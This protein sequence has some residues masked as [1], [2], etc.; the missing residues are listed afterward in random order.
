M[1]PSSEILQLLRKRF[2]LSQEKFG[3]FIGL[4]RSHVC[5]IETGKRYAPSLT[6]LEP[7]KLM[8]KLSEHDYEQLIVATSLSPKRIRIPPDSPEIAFKFATALSARWGSMSAEAFEQLY[9]LVSTS[10]D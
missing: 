1:S 8:L 5:A 7:L 2:G 6:Q 3:S 4:Q 9:K 10:A